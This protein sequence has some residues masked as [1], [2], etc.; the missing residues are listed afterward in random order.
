MKIKDFGK[1]SGKK[2]IKIISNNEVD[3]KTKIISGIL[4]ICVSFMVFYSCQKDNGSPTSPSNFSAKGSDYCPFNSGNIV[5]VK[6]SGSSAIYDSLGNITS[7]TQISNQAYSGSLGTSAMVNNMLSYPVYYYNRNN[8]STRAGYLTNNSGEIIG[9]TNS[10]NDPNLTLLPANLTI[11]MEWIV[12]PQ[13][14]TNEQIKGK[15]I[16]A[17]DSYTN[18]TGNSYQNVINLNLSLKDSTIATNI[19]TG[20]YD[21]E[22]ERI[23][24]DANLYFAKGIGI[25]GATLNNYERIQKVNYR[26]GTYTYNFY[27]RQQ[28]N[29]VCGVSN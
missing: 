1:S 29:G 28:T 13:S 25:V 3:M 22:Y 24:C 10:N 4:I 17:L 5:Y 26:S 7:T 18:S 12:N 27:K 14:S 21:K 8:S 23:I 6:I 20:G 16:E 15:I 11:G 19:I 9:F 2:T